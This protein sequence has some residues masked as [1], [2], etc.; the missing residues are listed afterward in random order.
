V[1]LPIEGMVPL[2]VDLS[3]AVVLRKCVH[4]SCVTVARSATFSCSQ[5]GATP[6]DDTQSRFNW[7]QLWSNARAQTPARLIQLLVAVLSGEWNLAQPP[8]S[9][10]VCSHSRVHNRHLR[11]ALLPG[12][13]DRGPGFDSRRYQIFL[14]AVGLERGPLS[15]CED[16]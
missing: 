6:P 13:R 3:R 14:V 8:H 5:A 4:I 2:E 1:R 7:C 16:K 11:T 15:P 10:G 12:C 9:K